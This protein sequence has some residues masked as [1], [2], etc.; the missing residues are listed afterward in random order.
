MTAIWQPVTGINSLY[1]IFCEI[2][3]AFK[4]PHLSA[5]AKKSLFVWVGA[6]RH[7]QHFFSHGTFPGLNQYEASK[8][9]CLAQEHNTASLVRSRVRHITNCANGVPKMP[10]GILHTFSRG[11]FSHASLAGSGISFLA[12]LSRQAQKVS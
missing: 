4:M 5:C 3:R 2:S 1:I 8:M 11:F 7:S 12:H 6:L 10:L 9:N